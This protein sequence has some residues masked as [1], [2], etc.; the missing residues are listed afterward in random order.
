MYQD[1]THSFAGFIF[2]LKA[3]NLYFNEFL[4]LRQKSINSREKANKNTQMHWKFNN[5]ERKYVFS[6]NPYNSNKEIN[7]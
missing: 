6:Y 5:G 3:L 1:P 2:S 4:Q 7:E